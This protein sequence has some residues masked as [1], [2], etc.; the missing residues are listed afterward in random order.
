MG[1]H[2]PWGEVGIFNPLPPKSNKASLTPNFQAIRTSSDLDFD[3]F[4]P[5][6]LHIFCG[7]AGINDKLCLLYNP[8]VVKTGVVS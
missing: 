1:A 5:V 4:V 3:D 7:I 8:V 2:L 6:F